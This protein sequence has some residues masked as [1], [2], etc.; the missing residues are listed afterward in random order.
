MP[1][2]QRQIPRKFVIGKKENAFKNGWPRKRNEVVYCCPGGHRILMRGG[3]A[4]NR[5]GRCLTVLAVTR[6][7]AK[8]KETQTFVRDG[9]SGCSRTARPEAAGPKEP[10]QNTP[11]QLAQRARARKEAPEEVREGRQRAQVCGHVVVRFSTTRKY[12][13]W[14]HEWQQRLKPSDSG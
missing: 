8:F 11:P 6:D 9:K 14:R 1:T 10:G 3:I 13:H 7:V 5:K 4:A 2:K 12:T